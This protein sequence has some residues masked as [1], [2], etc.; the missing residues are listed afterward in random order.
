MKH[1]YT[2]V[3]L[4]FNLLIFSTPCN[5]ADSCVFNPEWDSDH[6][7]FF[8]PAISSEDRSLVPFS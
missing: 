8:D 7:R 6:I 2:I 3:W 5:Q 4:V 1:L